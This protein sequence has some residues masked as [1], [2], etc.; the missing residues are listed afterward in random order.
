M[1]KLI[2]GSEGAHRVERPPG[3]GYGHRIERIGPDDFVLSWTFDTKISGSRLRW[4]R[5][6]YRWTDEAGARRFAAKWGC[7]FPEGARCHGRG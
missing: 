7:E 5:K 2:Q 6:I 3:T 1:L 4:P